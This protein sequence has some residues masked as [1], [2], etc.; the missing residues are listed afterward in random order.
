LRTAEAALAY[1]GT[2][3][4]EATNVSE[5]RGTDAPFLLFGAPGLDTASLLD[6]LSAPAARLGFSL[7]AEEF[8]PRRSAAAAKPKH[9]GRRC[10]GF[11]V[12][13]L[14]GV[15]GRPY[16]LGVELLSR[17]RTEPGVALLEQGQVLDRLLGSRSLRE[18]LEAGRSPEAILAADEPGIAAFRKERAPFLLY[19]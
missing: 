12:A 3:L 2:C 14:A 6:R 5:G 4:L 19:E 16:A 13:P 11:R 1:P 8:V 17:L 15:A 7:R 10:R 9:E 18:G